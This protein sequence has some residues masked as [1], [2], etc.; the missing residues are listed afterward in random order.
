MEVKLNEPQMGV[1]MLS[2]TYE[3]LETEYAV[4]K[5]EKVV[6]RP[7]FVIVIFAPR[8]GKL[9]MDFKSFVRRLW[10]RLFR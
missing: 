6:L 7:E 9:W 1:P 5:I 3:G 4:E 8:P 2:V 10:A